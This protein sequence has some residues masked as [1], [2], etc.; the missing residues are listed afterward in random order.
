MTGV[1]T[2]VTVT[3]ITLGSPSVVNILNTYKGPEHYVAVTWEP[4]LEATSYTVSFKKGGTTHLTYTVY[5][6]S[7][8][9]SGQELAE[10]YGGDGPWRALT[11]QVAA[12]AA[13]LVS[14]I[15]TD[16]E[17]DTAPAAP[18]GMSGSDGGGQADLSWSANSEDDVKQYR[19]FASNSSGFT[20]G[21]SND[22]GVTTG[23]SMSI[24]VAA[25]T[26][27]WV[28]QAEDYVDSGESFNPCAEQTVVIA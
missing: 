14:G 11:V 2:L 22:Q 25:G 16:T 21:P 8:Y 27:Y 12:N 6:N 9:V 17:T 3:G 7:I 20:P 15:V 24:S 5:S 19:V 26:Y 23:L 4:V 10:A 1:A 28:V 13:G 18:T